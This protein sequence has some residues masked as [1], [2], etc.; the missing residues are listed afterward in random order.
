M[1]LK[2]IGALV[3]TYFVSRAARRLPLPVRG[4]GATILAHILSFAAIA[5]VVFALRHNAQ[6][7]QLG[8]LWVYVAAQLA[9]LGVDIARADWRITG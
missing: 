6:V 3:L 1:L 4:T 8:Q 7:F 9:W 2:F 5:L